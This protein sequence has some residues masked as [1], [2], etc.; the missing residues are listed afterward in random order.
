MPAPAETPQK[1]APTI[2]AWVLVIPVQPVMKSPSATKANSLFRFIPASQKTE[3]FPA[4][5]MT[6]RRVCQVDFGTFTPLP[7]LE[8]TTD[9]TRFC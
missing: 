6:S 5:R 3:I 8:E 1:L 9:I 2:A 4:Q 7:N